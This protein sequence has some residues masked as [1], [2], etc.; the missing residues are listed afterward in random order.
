MEA[1]R[2]PFHGKAM[3]DAD[4]SCNTQRLLPS[5]E[6]L[7]A[8]TKMHCERDVWTEGTAGAKATLGAGGHSSGLF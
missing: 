3:E 6:C 5:W 2:R 7:F 8:T 4:T 1:A